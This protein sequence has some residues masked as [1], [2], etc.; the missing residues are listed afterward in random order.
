MFIIHKFPG[1]HFVCLP[2]RFFGVFFFV[3]FSVRLYWRLKVNIFLF[4]GWGPVLV[5]VDCRSFVNITCARQFLLDV[6]FKLDYGERLPIWF[7]CA[8][9]TE[10]SDMDEE[11]AGSGINGGL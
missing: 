10:E 4:D 9:K 7:G 6:Q 1:E 5:V 8:K 3:Y 11:L 2:F